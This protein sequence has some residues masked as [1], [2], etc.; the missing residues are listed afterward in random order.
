[1]CSNLYLQKSRVRQL[2][3]GHGCRGEDVRDA[4]ELPRLGKQP[5]IFINY[6]KLI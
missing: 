1:M 2:I 5:I 4:Y 6:F 3:H